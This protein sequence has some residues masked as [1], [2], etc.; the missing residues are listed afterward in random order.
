MSWAGWLHLIGRLDNGNDPL[1]PGGDNSAIDSSIAEEEQG[2][3]SI[4]GNLLPVDRGDDNDD[5][6]EE[7]SN[8]SQALDAA[9]NDDGRGQGPPTPQALPGENEMVQKM[10][11]CKA[12]R[13]FATVKDATVKGL[14]RERALFLCHCLNCVNAGVKRRQVFYLPRKDLKKNGIKETRYGHLDPNQALPSGRPPWWNLCLAS[15]S[16]GRSSSSSQP[17]E[18]TAKAYCITVLYCCCS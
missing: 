12:P 7:E 8:D 6:D 17:A 13:K 9:S 2:D 15:G 3:S 14:V 1:A 16:H 18:R 4:G 5:D 11:C 10:Q